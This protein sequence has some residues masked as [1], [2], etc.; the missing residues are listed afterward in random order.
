MR[1]LYD[2]LE[3]AEHFLMALG[4]DISARKEAKR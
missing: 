1:E 4:I 2:E 3:R